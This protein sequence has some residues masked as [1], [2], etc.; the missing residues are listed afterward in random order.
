MPAHT[1]HAEQRAMSERVARR[2]TLPPRARAARTRRAAAIHRRA[3][4]GFVEK[5]A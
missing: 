5:V 3:A 2:F 4:R 1:P